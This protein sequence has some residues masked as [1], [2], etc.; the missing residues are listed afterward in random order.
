MSAAAEEEE[1]LDW[2]PPTYRF[3]PTQRELVQFYLLPRA[4]GQDP[5]PGV[6]IEDD[7]AGTSLPWDLFER[8]G[9]G[10]EDEA[11]FLVRTSDAKRPGARQGRGCDGGV[12]AWK[13]Q[14]NVVKGLRVGGEKIRCR[15]SNL[16]LHMG[17]GKNGGSVG[18]V[19]HEYTIAAPPCP[20]PVKICHIAFT[21]HGRKRKRVPDGQE[22]SHIGH[23]SQRPR[24]DA[25]AA[26]CSC[27][28]VMLDR[29]SGAVVYASAE[30]QRSQLVLTEDDVFTQ[31]PLLG[32]SDF[33]GFPSAASGNAEN[34][35]ELEQQVLSTEEHQVMVPQLMVQQSSMAEQL[36]SIGADVQS[37]NC[38]GQEFWSS[39]VVGSNSV[40]TSIRDMA[41]A[42]GNA[43]QYQEL[44]QHVPSTEEQQV[45]MPQL[46]VQQS[47]MPEQLCA[48][49]LE[50]WSSIGV[51]VQSN[52]C[53]D[54][55]FWSSI[56]V[57][58]NSTVPRIG[59]MAAASSNA[60]Q[61]QELD[62]Q[63]LSTE[64]QRG[65]MSKLMVQ[66]SSMPEQL[67]GGEL[68]FCCSTRT[69]VQSNIC[70]EQEVW[71]SIGTE[72]N[73][74]VPRISDMAGNHQDQQ[75][76]W[77]LSRADVQSNCAVDMA[78]ASGNAE[79]Y[80]EFEQ[81]VPSTDEQQAMMPQ[82]MVQQSIMPEQLCAGEL[83][84]RSSIGAET[85]STVPRIGDM[86]G[87]HQDQ[88]DLWSL[89]RADVQSNCA[90]PDMAAGAFGGAQWGGYC[91]TC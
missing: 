24:V 45:M 44:E 41:A 63:V 57:E 60:E 37:I 47:S 69:N 29:D 14:S 79:Q 83:K 54:Q 75:D 18:W 71:S 90:V 62:Q 53:A 12:G 13:M 64:E 3:R 5:F 8:H 73:S 38:A 39:I 74:M 61:Y 76:R 72:S 21:G 59:D 23:A 43:E 86:A 77:S 48:G 26:G 22:D 50:F 11:Y 33:L 27:S 46:M 35:Q 49:E 91:I 81:Q 2:V 82:L 55:E 1:I 70:A 25:T 42:S 10:S 31:S 85:N 9:L 80:P 65:M 87:D 58:S 51:N 89:S 7:A 66:Q 36:S 28:G 84:L 32:S 78:A 4:R 30:E 56:G 68:E 88:Q 67:C 40:V 16:N 17:K 6:I 15:K 34:Y 19:M 52:I 20:S